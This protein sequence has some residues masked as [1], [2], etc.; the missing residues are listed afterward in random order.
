MLKESYESLEKRSEKQA[1]HIKLLENTVKCLQE[2]YTALMRGW[3]ARKSATDPARDPLYRVEVAEKWTGK[4]VVSLWV[5]TLLSAKVIQAALLEV[6][7]CRS[8]FVEVTIK[9]DVYA[10]TGVFNTL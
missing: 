8:F 5:P 7:T 6:F 2:D 10:E 3:Y 1:D 4:R 9:E